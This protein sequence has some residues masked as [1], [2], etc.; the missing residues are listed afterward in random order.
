MRL[1][2]HAGTPKTGTTSLQLALEKRREWLA[3]RGIAYPLTGGGPSPRH[4]WMIESLKGTQPN[5][6]ANE[7]Q[8]AMQFIS[9]PIHT[10]VLSSEGL[11]NHWWDF[12]ASGRQAL[13]SLRASFDV[14]MWVWLRE[15][16]SFARSLYVQM[17]RNPR[18]QGIPCYGQASSLEEMLD[19]QWFA[20]H[21]DY[22][23]FIKDVESLLG[24]NT[25]VPYV[26]R[27]DTVQ[28][29]FQE[30]NLA[31]DEPGARNEN[32]SLGGLAADLLR[33]VNR[34]DLAG[35]ARA[36]AIEHIAKI[37]A[38]SGSKP[39]LLTSQTQAKIRELTADSLRALEVNYGLTFAEC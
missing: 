19:N 20:K 14:R 23:G 3:L 24:S 25:V 17:L 4:Q 15:P 36:Q 8:R 11:F 13:R 7:L 5:A 18:V 16:V 9:E 34:Y 29:F 22:I 33:V 31:Y 21:L 12:S 37:D 26:Y 32:P 38:L 39:P 27:G 35:E 2:L 1:I 28:T 10:V 30:L 6:L